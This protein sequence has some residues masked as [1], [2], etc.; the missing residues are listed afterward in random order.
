MI[1]SIDTGHPVINGGLVAEEYTIESCIALPNI[2]DWWSA[3]TTFSDLNGSKVIRLKPLKIGGTRTLEQPTDTKRPLLTPNL[4][5]TD[6]PAIVFDGIDDWMQVSSAIDMSGQFGFGLIY[7]PLR[8]SIVEGLAGSF[9]SGTAR[10]SV[11]KTSTGGGLQGTCGSATINAA[12]P[13]VIGSWNTLRH[14]K[15]NINETDR[16]VYLR[17]NGVEATPLV[18]DNNTGSLPMLLGTVSTGGTW[19][20]IYVSDFFLINDDFDAAGW[21]IMNDFSSESYNVPF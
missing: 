13:S 20:N 6:N 4:I 2:T 19:A 8:A 9:T 3:E 11:N 5:G 15:N 18:H 10:F 21:A 12:S 17:S 1:G 16:R 14:Y 7:K